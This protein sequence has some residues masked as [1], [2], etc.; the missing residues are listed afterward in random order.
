MVFQELL[1]KASAWVPGCGIEIPCKYRY[2][3]YGVKDCSS[4]W[5]RLRDAQ[6][7]WKLPRTDD[8]IWH[9]LLYAYMYASNFATLNNTH[10]ILMHCMLKGKFF[11]FVLVTGQPWKHCR[12]YILDQSCNFVTFMKTL[13]VRQLFISFLVARVLKIVKIYSSYTWQAWYLS[14]VITA[15]FSPETCLVTAASFYPIANLTSTKL[16]FCT[17]WSETS[18]NTGC[19]RREATC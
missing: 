3:Q 12:R 8:W 16:N 9:C 19:W 14:D 5:R 4:I 11:S 10:F 18:R 6:K 7:S 17:A 2:V 1:L 15:V 13:E